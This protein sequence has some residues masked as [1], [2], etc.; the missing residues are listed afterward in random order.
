MNTMLADAVTAVG[1]FATG[2]L[3]LGLL[4]FIA[5]HA[6]ARWTIRTIDRNEDA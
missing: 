6:Y 1:T 5:L 4:L 3:G 2:L